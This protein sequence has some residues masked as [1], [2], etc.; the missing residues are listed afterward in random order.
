MFIQVWEAVHYNTLEGITW[1]HMLDPTPCQSSSNLWGWDLKMSVYILAL[2]LLQAPQMLLICDQDRELLHYFNT[3]YLLLLAFPHGLRSE[4][5]GRR[6]RYQQAW[7]RPLTESR[8][9][10]V[11]PWCLSFPATVGELMILHFGHLW[12]DSLPNLGARC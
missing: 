4:F 1:P 11:S 10:S 9:L 7:E 8:R 2:V 6:K 5:S 3:L 12:L